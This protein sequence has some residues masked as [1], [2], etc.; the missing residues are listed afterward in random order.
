MAMEKGCLSG[1]NR[2]AT[3]AKRVATFTRLQPLFMIRT[4]IVGEAAG[5]RRAGERSG[6]DSLVLPLREHV[7]PS[8]L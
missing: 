6:K 7:P 3:K 4:L 1:N 8:S 2:F 5:K